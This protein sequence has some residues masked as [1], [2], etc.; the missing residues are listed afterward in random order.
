MLPTEPAPRHRA[1]AATFT[2]LVE[3]THDWEAPAPVAGWTARDVVDHLTSWF[4]SFVH[5]G[6]PYGW[7][8]RHHAAD[9]PAAAWR[10]QCT[11]VQL[12]LDDPA[13]AESR[14]QHPRLPP[15]RLDEAIDRFYTA[16][17]FMHAWDLARATGQEVELDPDLAEELL[18][19]MRPMESMLR[20]SGQYGPAVPVAADAGVVDQLVGFIGRDPGWRPPA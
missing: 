17:V 2:A 20:E 11:A 4:P 13:Q 9:D 19:G 6:S 14:F 15:G 16:D 8:Q 18:A 1:V 10:E 12:L 3:R 5:A 7:N